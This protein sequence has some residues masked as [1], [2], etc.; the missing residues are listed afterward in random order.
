MVNANYLGDAPDADLGF[1]DAAADSV[2]GL[3][4]TLVI[5]NEYDDLRTSGDL[6]VAQATR[7]GCRV[8]RVLASGMLHGHLNRTPVIPEVDRTLRQIGRVVEQADVQPD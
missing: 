5:V 8:E 3:P 6:L 1:L 4:P 7:G 2:A